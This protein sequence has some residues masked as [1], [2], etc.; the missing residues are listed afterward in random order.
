LPM[1]PQPTTVTFWMDG[2]GLLPEEGGVFDS[3]FMNQN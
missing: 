1:V 3:I 2:A